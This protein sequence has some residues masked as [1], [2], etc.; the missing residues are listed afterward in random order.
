MARSTLSHTKKTRTRSQRKHVALPK[1]LIDEVDKLIGKDERTQ[2]LI[3]TVEERLISLRQLRALEQ[4]VGAWKDEDH[5]E[6]KNGSVA[7]QRKIRKEWEV[8]LK[9]QYRHA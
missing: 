4:A 1:A 5:P 3:K 7:W 6:L 9:K 8:R 2:F